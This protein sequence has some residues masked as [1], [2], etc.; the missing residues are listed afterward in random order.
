M[1]SASNSVVHQNNTHAVLL[2]ACDTGELQGFVKKKKKK[3]TKQSMKARESLKEGLRLH[4]ISIRSTVPKH[5]K[6]YK[7]SK[8]LS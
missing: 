1:N 3:T 7:F 6:L 8:I 5:F 4:W 2:Q